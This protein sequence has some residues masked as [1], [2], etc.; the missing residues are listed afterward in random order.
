MGIIAE[1]QTVK[2]IWYNFFKKGKIGKIFRSLI[3]K[4]QLAILIV[5]IWSDLSVCATLIAFVTIKG[6][7]SDQDGL[8]WRLISP[9]YHVSPFRILCLFASYVKDAIFCVSSK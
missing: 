3:V 8:N 2:T 7:S 9:I 6:I 1:N 5:R 4:F